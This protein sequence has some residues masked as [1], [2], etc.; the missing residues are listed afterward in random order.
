MRTRNSGLQYAC[1][2]ALDAC[3]CGIFDIDT[4]VS[5]FPLSSCWGVDFSLCY[6]LLVTCKGRY[7]VSVICCHDAGSKVSIPALLFQRRDSC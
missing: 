1:C 7:G 5:H 2:C 4:F 6:L 3:F